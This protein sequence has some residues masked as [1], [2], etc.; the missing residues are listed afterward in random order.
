MIETLK[1]VGHWDW[2]RL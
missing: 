2:A 1:R